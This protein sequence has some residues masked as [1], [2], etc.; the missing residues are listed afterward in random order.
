MRTGPQYSSA[1]NAIGRSNVALC[2]ALLLP[3]SAYYVFEVTLGTFHTLS[4]NTDYYDLLARGFAEGHLYVPVVPKAKLLRLADPYDSTYQHLWLWD[5]TLFHGRYYMYWGPAP[6][7][8][9]LAFKT[10]TGY[11]ARVYDQWL[12]LVFMLG[13]MY[14]GT[15]LILSFANRRGARQPSWAILL[16]VTVFAVASP[17][18]Y[19]MARPLIYE[20][21]IGAGQCFLFCGWLAAFWGVVNRAWR[22]P[23]FVL[24]GTCWAMAMSSRGS[25]ILVGPLL[26]MLTAWFATRRERESFADMVRSAVALGTPIALSLIAY[27]V[28][29]YERFGTPTEFG[30]TYQLTS[31]PFMNDNAFLLPNLV[32]YLGAPLRWSCHFPFARLP[33]D[34]H[35]TKLISWP[36][37]YDVGD[38]DNGER[39]AG[40][41]VATNYSW[42]AVLWL[43]LPAIARL[44]SRRQNDDVIRKRSWS[45]TERWALLCGF[46][47]TCALLPVFRMY[48]ANMRFLEDGIGGLLIASMLGGFWL[49]RRSRNNVTHPVLRALGPT[50][51]VLLAL[52]SIVIGLCLG[53]SGHVD[54]FETQNPEL[55]GTLKDQLS[56]CRKH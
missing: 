10:L 35:L 56:V 55:F 24:A 9:L 11:S 3:L 49:I 52:H 27:G 12:V 29:N 43:M 16:A 1:D 17:T 26:V 47:S 50:T 25:L 48:M 45:A 44:R 33:I 21:A 30:L 37:A 38:Y 6:A 13:R 31:R 7:L 32:S 41:L 5:A 2:V 23:L 54:N 53:F 22:T 19:V 51:Y 8:C 42:L 20:A 46:A 36:A 15:A 14:A 40:V 4:W 18:P 34:R 39:I 28:Y